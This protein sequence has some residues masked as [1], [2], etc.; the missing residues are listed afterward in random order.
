MGSKLKKY[1]SAI[2]SI[3]NG[4]AKIKYANIVGGNQLIIDSKNN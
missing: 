4:Y 1:E 2:L 3:L